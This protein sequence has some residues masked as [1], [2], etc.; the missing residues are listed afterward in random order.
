MALWDDTEFQTQY[1]TVKTLFS[2]LRKKMANLPPSTDKSSSSDPTPPR[3]FRPRAAPLHLDVPKFKGD[4]LRWESFETNLKSVL[5]DRAEGF[6]R[7]DKFTVIQQAIL[8][9][10]GKSQVADLL[11]TGATVE[12]LLA[13]LRHNFGRP[14]LVIP[15]LVKK[16]SV[17]PQNV[18][19]ISELKHFKESVLDSCK[20]LTSVLKNDLRL[21]LPH[22]LRHHLAGKFGEDWEHLLFE[23]FDNPTFDDLFTFVKQ[24]LLW[25]QPHNSNTPPAKPTTPPSSVSGHS[26]SAG[27]SAK[28]RGATP[29]KCASCGEAH[30]V[31]RC[32][33]FTAL[34]TEARNRL[35]REKRLCLNCL[36]PAHTVRQCNNKHSCR[37]CNLR[38][39]SLLHREQHP[40]AG[41]STPQAAPTTVAA[42]DSTE[43]GAAATSNPDSGYFT[44]TVTARVQHED[45]I[46][47]TRV[48]LDHGSGSCFMSEE[49]ASSLRLPRSPQDKL[50][51]GFGKGTVRSRFKV[52]AS[53]CSTTSSFA[54]SPITFSIIP[55]S[56]H[57]SPPAELDL[58]LGRASEL[59]LTL[60]DSALGGRVDVILGGAY[61]WDLCGEV[62]TQGPFRFIHTRFGYSAVGPLQA[63]P[64][65][66]T[67]AESDSTLKDDLQKLWALD[68]VPETTIMSEP[69]KQALSNFQ[70]TTTL[71]DGR[72]QVTLPFRKDAL[73]LGNSKRQALSRFFH[74]ERSLRAKGKLND[75]NLALNEYLELGHAHVI[76]AH[77]IDTKQPVYYMPVHGV[78]KD[79]S[80]TTKVRPVFDASAKTSTGTSLNDCLLIGP[81]LYPQLADVLLQFRLHPVGLSADISKM[82]REIR[83][84][85]AFRDY[86]RFL[87]RR[88]EGQISDCRMERVTFGVASSPFLATQTLRFIAD[89]FREAYPRAARLI[90]TVFYVDDFVAGAANVHN[91]DNI[92]DE[93][94]ELLSKAGMTLRK[95]RSNSAEFLDHTPACLREV[96]TTT[97]QLQESPKALGAHWDTANDSL[98]IAIPE[99]PKPDS[100]VTKRVVASISASV[101]DILGLFAPTTII[102][103]M[104]LQE[105][106]KLHLPWDKELPQVLKE[107]WA[108]WTADL[109]HVKSYAISRT[110]FKNAA[111]I[112]FTTLHGF[113]DASDKAYGAVVY[114]RVVNKDSSVYTTL[115]TAKARVLPIK[116]TTVPRAELL[117][118]LL[119]AKLLSHVARLLNISN[120]NLFTWTDSSI[121]L[122]WLSKDASQLSDRFVA[123]RVQA[124][125]DLLPHVKW[126]HVRTHDNPADLASRGVSASSLVQSTLWWAGPSWLSQPPDSWPILHIG[127]PK[128]SL[129]ILTISPVHTMDSARQE[130]LDGLWR[131]ISF[132]HTLERVVAWIFRFYQRAR[133]KAQI[134]ATALS[135]S[136]LQ[137]SRSKLISLSQHQ[138][139][140]EVFDFVANDKVPPKSHP[141]HQFLPT[142]IN[143]QL[144]LKSRVRSS[145]SHSSPQLLTPLHQKSLFTQL[146]LAT[147]HNSMLHPGV[148]ALQS[149]ISRTFYVPGLRNVLKKLSRL[150]PQCQRAYAKPLLHQL[151]LLP[152]VRTTPSPPFT[153]VGVDFAGPLMLRRGH[154]R[155]PV[156]VKAY[157]AVFVCMATKAVHLDLC[158]SLST[159]DFLASLTRFV[160]RRGCPTDI[161]SDN[162]S[163][164][165]GAR[166]EIRTVE[167]LFG[168][169]DF[170][171]RRSRFSQQNGINWHN[172]PPRAPHFGGLWEAAVRSM[173]V[174]LRK[175]LSPHHLRF[176]EMYTLLTE[177]ESIFNSRPLTPLK[178]DEVAGGQVLTAGHFL[179]GRP[180]KALP[181]PVV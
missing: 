149:I 144:Q 167:A 171:E 8:P 160:A 99:L 110:Y 176:D 178:K 162:G 157:V 170:K 131:R 115:V 126:K 155:K 48:L 20:L 177:A 28:A 18:Q 80:T 77:E 73:P 59:G 118:A 130:F 82:F 46:K 105:T 168:S 125:H 127:R 93:L 44:C 21:F 120:D 4:P 67:I 92:R 32:Q 88:N 104:I 6:S 100:K 39:H 112:M 164:F 121:V 66:L 141:L 84:D 79:S 116:H 47:L 98:H 83:L 19:T 179:I 25:L 156:I 71:Q 51:K 96:A 165:V 60:S 43:A 137:A 142:I 114:L 37:H 172:I 169:R 174:L 136:E 40:S 38:H 81:N 70:E 45:T 64:T 61:P 97:L 139:F 108:S 166:E 123:S 68:K 109:P 163:N 103:R 74:N 107:S 91:A 145:H 16:I 57:T 10:E 3:D 94:C 152:A 9:E 181:S 49:L 117:G 56:L 55:H 175:N 35:A 36:S 101:F 24:R 113:S 78:F 128:E 13:E 62:I 143:E 31:G 50:F 87:L 22:F 63:A 146:L 54:T 140:P 95:W 106:W 154:T 102:P 159:E 111:S 41:T 129:T 7:A 134:S 30:W 29:P 72:V 58:V 11:K 14:Q 33:S 90:E 151:G 86:H 75:F 173:K 122:H 85:P 119:L 5:A 158:A 135:S 153:K 133:F 150:C 1:T 147:Y 69:D 89:K 180:L 65:I 27:T 26:H 76:P 12:K 15:L 124:C 2:D 34:D 148:S 23:K 52:Y 17:P 132:L 161:Y 138:S 53:L 42:V